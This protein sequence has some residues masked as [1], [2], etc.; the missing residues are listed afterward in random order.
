MAIYY[1]LVFVLVAFCLTKSQLCNVVV[2]I[3]MPYI[4]ESSQ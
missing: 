1:L 2:F 3:G 4:S